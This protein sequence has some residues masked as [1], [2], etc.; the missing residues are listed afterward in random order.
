M[1]REYQTRL[2]EACR[3]RNS[4]IK[5]L[6]IF[7]GQNIAPAQAV[8]V[9]TSVSERPIDS[10][11]KPKI[12][13]I[14]KGQLK[15]INDFYRDSEGTDLNLKQKHIGEARWSLDGITTI[16]LIDFELDDEQMD[17]LILTPNKFGWDVELKQY[18]SVRGET[19]L[20][21][22]MEWFVRG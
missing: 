4:S 13:E 11:I 12:I 2:E 5:A 16:D 17:L 6:Q 14:G 10:A 9:T 15:D 7:K 19:R 20:V 21:S 3:L 22:Y 18:L 8:Q 1:R